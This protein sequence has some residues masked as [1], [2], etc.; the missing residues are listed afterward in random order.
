M[1]KKIENRKIQ[2]NKNFIA[3]SIDSI[4]HKGRLLEPN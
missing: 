4:E 3:K 2:A 1:K